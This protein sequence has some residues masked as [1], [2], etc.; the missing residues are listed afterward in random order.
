M[1][2][3]SNTERFKDLLE[4]Y[5]DGIISV[6]DME[7]LYR[8]ISSNSEMLK[9]FRTHLIMEE[10]LSQ[11]HSPMRQGDNF[12]EAFKTRLHAEASSGE[13]VKDFEKALTQ[14]KK[15]GKKPVKIQKKTSKKKTI[16]YQPPKKNN[17]FK[18]LA[19]AASFAAAIGLVFYM[20]KEKQPTM[21]PIAQ[22]TAYKGS[23]KLLRNGRGKKVTIGAKVYPGD[24]LITEAGEV[25]FVYPDSTQ[26]KLLVKTKLLLA[27]GYKAKKM[28]MPYGVI[29]ANVAPQNSYYPMEI[30]SQ[31]SQITIIGT[32][33]QYRNTDNIAHLEVTKGKVRM[34]RLKDNKSVD[35]SGGEF[36]EVAKDVKFAVCKIESGSKETIPKTVS[37]QGTF[38]ENF[39]D[40]RSVNKNWNII[41]GEFRLQFK[42][43]MTVKNIGT[44]KFG[45]GW[46]KPAL[47]TTNKTFAVPFKVN[48]KIKDFDNSTNSIVGIAL[49]PANE[50]YDHINKQYSPNTFRI[51]QRGEV[52]NIQLGDSKYRKKHLWDIPSALTGAD[53]NNWEIEIYPEKFRLLINGQLVVEKDFTFQHEYKIMLMSEL[54][55]NS[56][57]ENKGIYAEF[58]QFSLQQ[59]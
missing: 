36:A 41:Q 21:K 32:V 20:I 10:A 47:L 42:N 35:V 7:E 49:V 3:N 58:S 17:S 1:T 53:L 29:E 46:M 59:K 5:S 45:A 50:K 37:S 48:S 52:F 15:Q 9:E 30:T 11:Y 34:T 39:V 16:P 51:Q 26:V 43:K 28:K 40:L 2:D 33:F 22:I 56:A 8:F 19:Y 38:N 31:T 23:C 18:F 13:F 25:T 6:E 54:K 14:Y 55:I 4:E 44:T 12:V 27:P 24:Q 57:R